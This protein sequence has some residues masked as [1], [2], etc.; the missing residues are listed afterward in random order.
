MSSQK[1]GIRAQELRNIIGM[2]ERFDLAGIY[3]SIVQKLV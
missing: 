2:K 1:M 3:E